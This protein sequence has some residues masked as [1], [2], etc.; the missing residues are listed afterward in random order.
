M[1]VSRIVCRVVVLLGILSHVLGTDDVEIGLLSTDDSLLPAGLAEYTSFNCSS[2]ST[3]YFSTTAV[4]ALLAIPQDTKIVVAGSVSITQPL[5]WNTSAQL[6]LI[7][8]SVIIS[9]VLTGTGNLVIQV[10]QEVQLTG[11]G[12]LAFGGS[13]VQIQYEVANGNFICVSQVNDPACV[14]NVPK[15]FFELV[16]AKTFTVYSIGAVANLYTG[17]MN[18][19]GTQLKIETIEML[20]DYQMQVNDVFDVSCSLTL[21]A[22]YTLK[23]LQSLRSS[24][25]IELRSDNDKADLEGEIVSAAPSCFLLPCS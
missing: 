8:A 23:V 21:H 19:S 10:T 3:C 25:A 20:S 16:E 5:S 1:A 18:F 13:Q 6:Q 17:N 22:S 7:A 14:L 9:Q 2:T 15:S 4:A 24:G 11:G 12:A